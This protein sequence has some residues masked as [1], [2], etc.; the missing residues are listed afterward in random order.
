MSSASYRRALNL[1]TKHPR[2]CQINIVQQ[3]QRLSEVMTR[4]RE[5][6]DF[7]CDSVIL[8]KAQ[9]ERL[10]RILS[11]GVLASS[12]STESKAAWVYPSCR[13]EQIITGPSQGVH[14]VELAEGKRW[15][16]TTICSQQDVTCT[17][18]LWIY[19]L[20]SYPLSHPLPVSLGPDFPYLI[21]MIRRFLRW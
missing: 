17:W 6:S 8:E 12:Y 20:F 3:A 5:E 19:M 11:D 1:R 16:S 7:A 13:I 14:D 18:N 2:L 9:G 21:S 10:F 15:H 4:S